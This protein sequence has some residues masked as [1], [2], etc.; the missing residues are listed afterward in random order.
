MTFDEYEKRRKQCA[1]SQ[2]KLPPL[3]KVGQAMPENPTW[4]TVWVLEPRNAEHADMI[5]AEEGHDSHRFGP[6]LQAI[7]GLECV[8]SI[9]EH[10]CEFP[11]W[12]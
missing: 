12:G 10:P 6:P 1:A 2:G 5:L 11:A 8:H 4:Y 9:P 3:M 7:V